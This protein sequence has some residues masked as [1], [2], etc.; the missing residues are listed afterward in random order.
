M[1][2]VCL[3]MIFNPLHYFTSYLIKD[4]LIE[5]TF[6]RKGSSYL[7]CNDRKHIIFFTF[8]KPKKIFMGFYK[9]Y[10]MH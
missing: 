3:L 2:P 4:K 1:L 6:N 5:R 8:E 10:E 9:M 7:A